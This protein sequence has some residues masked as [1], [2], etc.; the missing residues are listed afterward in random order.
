MHRNRLDGLKFRIMET[1]EQAKGVPLTALEITDRLHAGE[2]KDVLK[3]ALGLKVTQ[4]MHSMVGKGEVVVTDATDKDGRRTYQLPR[5]L[6]FPPETKLA[7]ANPVLTPEVA[8]QIQ[9]VEPKEEPEKK[10]GKAPVYVPDI[11]E[12]VIALLNKAEQPLTSKDIIAELGHLYPPQVQSKIITIF[13]GV[14]LHLHK[15]RKVLRNSVRGRGKGVLFEYYTRKTKKPQTVLPLAQPAQ[16]AVAH[17]SVS[18]VPPAPK[19]ANDG[20]LLFRPKPVAPKAPVSLKL[21]EHTYKRVEAVALKFD[22]TIE[23]LC[24]QAIVFA[25]DHSE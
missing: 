16:P 8:K 15:Q 3:D 11:G 7:P 6:K 21:S 9:T 13:G 5:R 18:H 25:L 14:L 1:L 12:R 20:A 2:Y 19:P 23:A 22:M 4:S 10:S 24:A 17:V